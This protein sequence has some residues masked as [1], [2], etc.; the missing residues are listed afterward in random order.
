MKTLILILIALTLTTPAWADDLGCFENGN[1]VYATVQFNGATGESAATSVTARVYDPDDTTTP[2]HTPTMSAVDGTNAIGLYRGSFA[3]SSPLAGTWTIRYRGSL[4]GGTSF[5][6][7]TDT[8]VVKAS[9]P[10]PAT[11]A[12]TLPSIPA[13]WITAAGI[14]A[15][16]LNDKGN[17]VK[18]TDLDDTATVIN[19]I[20][21][22]T[23]AEARSAGT[24]GQLLKDNINAT[25][26]SRQPSGNVT[27]GGYATNQS[28]ADLVL[29][30]P[31]QKIAT[32]ASNQVVSSSVQGNVTGSVASVTNDVGITQ[33]GADKVWSTATRTI[34]GGTIGTYTGNTPQTGDAFARLGAPAGASVSA[35]IATVKSD[36][37]A[38]K[39]KTDYLP[40]ATAGQ[41]GGVFIAGSNAATTANITG[42]ITGNLSGSVGS[43]ATNGITAGS[44]AADAITEAKVADTLEKRL[45]WV[46]SVDLTGNT[47]VFKLTLNSEGVAITNQYVGM[48]LYCGNES[49]EI[50]ASQSGAPDTIT[51]EPFNVWPSAPTSATCVVR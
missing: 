33:S 37:G 43:I 16:A 42:N 17:W 26:S 50:V 44:I 25:I 51:T 31:A 11:T 49:R 48:R 34:T 45:G 15:S 27:V 41:S 23:T 9:C 28:P 3:L 13:N 5:V 29:V 6:T 24:Y 12:V 22:E 47:G 8:F 38:I 40:S 2:S 7:A 1:T 21:E 10:L 46:A 4:D 14:N 32:N 39:T 18:T 19:A 35:D 36:T 30:T 20:Y